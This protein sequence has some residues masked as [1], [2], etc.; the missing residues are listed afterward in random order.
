MS[1]DR[2]IIRFIDSRYDEL[3]QIRDGDSIKISFPDG[4]TVERTCTFIDEYH[5]QVGYNVFHIC[6][7][8]EKM[9]EIGATYQPVS[10]PVKNNMQGRNRGDITAR[11]R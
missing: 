10:E 4:E 8:A 6:Q 5:T 11:K 3:F 1:D 7:F 9:E 2:K